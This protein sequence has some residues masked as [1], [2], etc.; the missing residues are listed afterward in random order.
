MDCLKTLKRENFRKK[1][2]SFLGKFKVHVCKQLSHKED[3]Y[4]NLTA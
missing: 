3:H 2:F 4:K 1:L